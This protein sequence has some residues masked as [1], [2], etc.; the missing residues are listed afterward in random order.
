MVLRIENIKWKY[1]DKHIAAHKL[2]PII[3]EKLDAIKV[4][5]KI[6]S[7]SSNECLDFIY[8]DSTK[9]RLFTSSVTNKTERGLNTER[10]TK[11]QFD[12]LVNS[13][14]SIF[15]DLNVMADVKLFEFESD[16][17]SFLLLKTGYNPLTWQPH[18]NF[19]KEK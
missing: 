7:A 16:P 1:N 9:K 2:V 13:F 8:V 15:K 5:Y 10:I 18:I 4:K 3:K 17:N 19:A 11:K 12:K 14:E 6:K